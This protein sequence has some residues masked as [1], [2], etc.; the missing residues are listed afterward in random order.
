MGVVLLVDFLR[1]AEEGRGSGR[2]SALGLDA[3]GIGLE[4]E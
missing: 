1:E 2:K 4:G 3:I